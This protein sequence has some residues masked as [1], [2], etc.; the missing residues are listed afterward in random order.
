L[1][2]LHLQLLLVGSDEFSG[3]LRFQLGD[4]DLSHPVFAGLLKGLV[5]ILLMNEHKWIGRVIQ[6]LFICLKLFVIH[7]DLT[8]VLLCCDDISLL[9]LVTLFFCFKI[10]VGLA[11]FCYSILQLIVQLGQ[12]H[13]CGSRICFKSHQ[14]VI[15]LLDLLDVLLVFDLKLMEVNELKVV[16][17]LILMVDLVLSLEDLNFERDVLRLQLV[18]EGLLLLQLIHHVL[19]ELFGVVLAD[20]AV[21]GGRK[22]PTEVKGFLTD[23]GD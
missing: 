23:L 3:L 15:S 1:V 5:G 11:C 14:L 6:R 21:F 22:E 10:C 18:D 19:G 8:E 17:H 20:A 2:A 12:G 9:L 4:L 16:A 7:P 13:N